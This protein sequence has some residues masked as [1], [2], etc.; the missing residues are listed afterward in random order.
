MSRAPI[1]CRHSAGTSSPSRCWTASSGRR[2]GCRRRDILPR[3]ARGP[4]RRRQQRDPA[5]HHPEN[6]GS[7][8][9]N[10]TASL[11]SPIHVGTLRLEHRLIMAAM[12]S[13]FASAEGRAT[14]RLVR[15]LA[16]RAEGGIALVTTEATA[17]DA[18]GAPFPVALRA[19]DDGMLEGL[20][21]VAEAVHAH[22]VPISMQLYHAGRQMSLRVSG[23]QPVAPS[24][25]PCPMV[26]ELPRA[27]EGEE[28][29][30]LVERFAEAAARA[31]EAGFDAI[32][33]HGSHG[34][35]IHQ[36]L[37]PLANQRTD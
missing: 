28:I 19:D 32:E 36:F 9:M 18:S 6:D 5:H 27:L 31:R 20:R 4:H 8:N 34:Y 30:A 3:L 35:L 13:G 7:R 37:T 22:G 24:A 15:Y 16:R 25:I 14:D 12:G 29:P 23:R 26:R 11:W 17:V 2:H 21:R 10:G 1:S 33:L